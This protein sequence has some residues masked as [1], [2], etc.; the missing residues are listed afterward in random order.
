MK[1]WVIAY[2]AD[3]ATHCLLGCYNSEAE[4]D[5][6]ITKCLANE[7]LMCMEPYRRDRIVKELNIATGPWPVWLMTRQL[8]P[9]QIVEYGRAFGGINGNSVPY[10]GTT[11]YSY[12]KIEINVPDWCDNFWLL[13][14]WSSDF[15]DETSL[16]IPHV[17]IFSSLPAAKFARNRYIANKVSGINH[18]KDEVSM[19]A[20]FINR[21]DHATEV[22]LED[23]FS[24][25]Y[26]QFG[27][28]KDQ[29]SDSND[30]ME[31]S[32]YPDGSD[33]VSIHIK[34]YPSWRYYDVD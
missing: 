26:S 2:R 22:S 34:K 16:D 33:D 3:L 19:P 30:P 20:D 18:Q 27:C 31:F 25:T 5:K 8:Q 21:D 11:I 15:Q 17:G 14:I 6:E 23:L 7:Y 1:K 4:A 12:Q 32:F 24:K 10:I 9:E 29:I 28:C 13:G